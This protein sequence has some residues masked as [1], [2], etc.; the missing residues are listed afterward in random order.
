MLT[1]ASG[2][3]VSLKTTFAAR[4]LLV[5]EDEGKMGLRER[6]GREQ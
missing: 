4:A 1:L 2:S 3:S 6:H 5:G